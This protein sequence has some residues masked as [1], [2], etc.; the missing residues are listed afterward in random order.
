MTNRG[1]DFRTLHIEG[2][3]RTFGGF[4]AL[5]GISLDIQRGEFVALLG[6]SGCGKSTALNC[7]AGLL[8]MTA[9]SLRLDEHVTN[10]HGVGILTLQRAL[11]GNVGGTV[12]RAVVDEHAVFLVLASF[13]H[14][15]AE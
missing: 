3:E 5:D 13:G 4:R 14:V 11:V 1:N 6:P 15:S 10:P 9:G 12:G 2:M 8:S 7:I